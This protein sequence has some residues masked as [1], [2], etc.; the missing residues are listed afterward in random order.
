MRL[1]VLALVL[2]ALT[3]ALA[4]CTAPEADESDDGSL[5]TP[6][7]NG[8]C[9]ADFAGPPGNNA[10]L[11]AAL[12]DDPEVV[13][14]RFAEALGE[15][16]EGAPEV[17]GPALRWSTPNGTVEQRRADDVV[18]LA[19]RPDASFAEDE[20]SARAVLQRALDAFFLPL[21]ASDARLVEGRLDLPQTFDGAPISAAGE[22]HA[23]F[24]TTGAFLVLG[25][26]PFLFGPV[27]D[28]QSPAALVT[29][30]RA[31]EVA[32]AYAACQEQD[33]GAVKEEG[34]TVVDAS[35]ARIV[36]VGPDAGC[37]G[38]RVLVDAETEAVRGERAIPCG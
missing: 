7:P 13:A 15:S 2:V 8:S 30:E 33:A 1:R 14:S 37:G 17:D 22:E 19:Y 16:L 36:R 25:D 12:Q 26:G 5:L 20:A 24:A 21:S 3:L 9:G 31:V 38:V 29:R 10:P 34:F 35:L 6:Q 23:E 28:V 32:R 18:Q 27:Y 11:H 4:G